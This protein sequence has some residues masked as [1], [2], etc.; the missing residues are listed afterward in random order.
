MLTIEIKNDG[1]GTERNANYVYV[2]LAND[3]VIETG[4]IKGH[5]RADG[6]RYLVTLIGTPPNFRS[7]IPAG[8]KIESHLTK[9]EGG[10]RV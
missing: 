7:A 6:W 10:R 8:V 4:S 2:V 3:E 9:R 5:N 1:T